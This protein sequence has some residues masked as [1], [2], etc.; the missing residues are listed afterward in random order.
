MALLLG[1]YIVR[2]VDMFSLATT[3]Y[4]SNHSVRKR[5]RSSFMQ[6][7]RA[8]AKDSIQLSCAACLS[9]RWR[10]S[11]KQH[12]SLARRI[13]TRPT[14]ATG[15]AARNSSWSARK[16]AINSARQRAFPTSDR[17]A[18]SLYMD[19]RR[20]SVATD[21]P[22]AKPCKRRCPLEMGTWRLVA[23]QAPRF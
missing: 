12:Q 20:L 8:C 7:F 23:K 3:T 19:L 15:E 6:L 22:T 2:L 13:F 21:N 11:W 10:G 9:S 1:Q 4:A 18:R 16:L 5:A 14:N 17:R